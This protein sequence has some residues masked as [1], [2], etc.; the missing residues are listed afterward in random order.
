FTGISG[1]QHDHGI[2]AFVFGPDGKL[3]FN[4]GNA[5]GQLKDKNGKLVIDMAGNPVTSNRQPYQE[6]MVFRCNLDGSEL[7]TLGWNFRN[8]W[9][10]T[11]DSFGTLWQSDNDDDGNRGV[12]IN[13]IM[14]FGN[15]GYR[16]EIT[17]A[18]WHV[19]R[20]GRHPDISS[21]HWH[22]NDPGVVPNVLQ[23][24]AGSPTGITVYEGDLL[25]EVFRGQMIHCDAGPGIVRAYP[26]ADAGAGYTASIVNILQGVRDDWFRP[27]DVSIAPD[28]SLFVADWYDPG[29]GGHQA[30]DLDSGRLFRVAPKSAE[31]YRVPEHN[32]ETP[33]G[34]VEA[35]KSPNYATRYMAW[36]ALHQMGEQAET[37]LLQLW[38]S[39]QSRLRARALWLL[40]KIAGKGPEYVSLACSDKDPNIRIVGIR[41]AR[42]LNLDL[43][44]IV[45]Q[46]ITDSS[47]K[48][49]R[50]LAIALR[51]NPA[52]DAARLWSELALKYDGK[53]R[54]YLEALGIGADR[55]WPEFLTAWHKIKPLDFDQFGTAEKDIIW[56]SRAPESIATLAQF[57]NQPGATRNEIA[58]Y[59]RAYDFIPADNKQTLL[60]ELALKGDRPLDPRDPIRAEALSRLSPAGLNKSH[61][62]VLKQLTAASA[63]SAAVADL[64]ERF[65]VAGH[66]ELLFDLVEQHPHAG[67]R[68]RAADLLLQRNRQDLVSK[69][70][71]SNR[72]L[73]TQWIQAV[74][75]ASHVKALELLLPYV[76]DNMLDVADRREAVR[77]IVRN[78]KGA[79]FLVSH[80]QAGTLDAQLNDVVAAALNSSPFPAI[81]GKVAQL[82][83]K[84]TSK[85]DHPLASLKELAQ[86]TG[87]AERG[88]LVFDGSGTCINC[89]QVGGNGKQVG[90][91]LDEIGSKLGKQALYESILYPNAGIS[92]NYETVLILLQSGQFLSGLVTSETE[93]SVQIKDTEALARNI[94]RDSIES[95]TRSPTSLMPSDLQTAMTAQ[96]LADL[97]QYLTTLKKLE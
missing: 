53:D 51:H 76:T 93:D 3:Y 72:T 22:L 69:G 15:Y 11:V 29:V 5:G 77:A 79:Q 23:T 55:Q 24:G 75:R 94:A 16:D 54:W 20:S 2:H 82:F 13:F 64:I 27:A 4:F 28:G 95:M 73:R 81:Q 44:P 86:R 90:P 36:T 92:H 26:V 61:H 78:L 74:G 10:V 67:L 80:I 63:G 7:E 48:V 32:F 12:R 21:R 96:E 87:D 68:G 66:D 33:L 39:P 58:R 37:E 60:A 40:G 8:N 46:L 70:L 57:I 31:R 41:L 83:P 97:V 59:F 30:R 71:T 1:E 14:E 9:M 91:A 35:L 56:R 6:G 38:K 47:P 50:E 43:V 45:K 88:K 84:P 85:D 49:C 65:D 89:H 17:G 25:P 52:P 62:Q 34:A 42:Q 19:G 18:G